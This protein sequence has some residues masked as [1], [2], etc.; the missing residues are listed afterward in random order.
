[1]EK[2]ILIYISSMW[3]CSD[4]FFIEVIYRHISAGDSVSILKC[5]GALKR[6]CSL[7]DRSAPFGTATGGCGQCMAIFNKMVSN[8]AIPKENISY[9]PGNEIECIP[10]RI[11]ESSQELNNF[12]FHG[13]DIGAAVLN[14][15]TMA[16]YDHEPDLRIHEEDVNNLIKDGIYLLKTFDDIVPNYSKVYFFNG[17]CI[18][19]RIPLRICQKRGIECLTM[20]YG[21][22]PGTV[23]FYKNTY[24][25]DLN[26]TKKDVERMWRTAPLEKIQIAESFFTDKRMRKERVCF[27]F[28]QKRN[29]LPIGYE[30]NRINIAIYD[31]SLLEMRGIPEYENDFSNWEFFLHY[32]YI[33]AGIF[34]HDEKYRFYLRAHPTMANVYTSLNTE[35]TASGQAKILRILRFA[36]LKNLHVILPHESVD[37]YSLLDHSDIVLTQGSTIGIEATYWGKPSITFGP[38]YYGRM[39]A[40]YLPKTHN[41]LVQL[42]QMPSLKPKPKEASLP[43]AYYYKMFGEPLISPKDWSWDKETTLYS[44]TKPAYAC[45]SYF[46]DKHVRNLI[47]DI[48]DTKVA[49]REKLCPEIVSA[50]SKKD[51]YIGKKNTAETVNDAADDFYTQKPTPAELDKFEKECKWLRENLRIPF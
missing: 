24:P 33:L 46:F 47:F 11:F 13:V 50:Y 16:Y 21:F 29:L 20:E 9:L 36:K 28:N 38:D 18:A 14:T 39:E 35:F 32:V 37:S 30:S 15:L 1:M 41:E 34:E 51:Y 8:F 44:N 5:N 22:P 3:V 10:R 7:T 31:S 27:T 45:K 26:L 2:K 12:S 43:F 25:Q 48:P 40:C 4:R 23:A 19:S 17:R 42:L 49:M 6:N